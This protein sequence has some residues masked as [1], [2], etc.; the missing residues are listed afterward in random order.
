MKCHIKFISSVLISL[1]CFLVSLN[2]LAYEISADGYGKS[3]LIARKNATT[4]LSESLLT[5][6]RSELN[7]TQRLSGLHKVSKTVRAI[8]ELPLL[9]VEFSSIEYPTEYYS[10]AQLS[11]K[12]SL[13]LYSSQ[14][15]KIY[16]EVSHLYNR[17]KNDQIKGSAKYAV[18]SDLYLLT[19]KYPQYKT[20]ATLLGGSGYAELPVSQE[21]IGAKLILI[22]SSV[23][24][25]GLAVK[26]LIRKLP[27]NSYYVQAFMPRGSKQATQFSRLLKDKISSM[28]STIDTLSE[29][30]YYLKGRYEE[31]NNDIL[32]TMRATDDLGST[33]MSQS[34]RLNKSAVTGIAYKSNT[35]DFNKLL[36]E[37]YVVSNNFRAELNSNQ[38]NEGLLF[39]PGQTIE[40]FV[41]I[42]GPGYYYVVSHNTSN[43][44]SY[45]LELNEAEGKRAFV[46]YV[47]A[48]DVNRWV[49][50]GSFEVTEPYGTENLQLIASNK[51]LI[52]NLPKVKFD[53]KS[54]LYVVESGTAEKAII[55]TRGLKPKKKGKVKSAE[56]TLTF[57]TMPN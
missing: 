39:T 42:N 10:L 20:V 56:A 37:G 16:K 23:T 44:L 12:K 31:L 4:A 8:S 28:V 22:E 11:S 41:K 27:K 40:L 18:L 30:S 38:G 55:T 50:L 13:Q 32:I 24:T 21:E 9:G 34:V 53:A 19:E 52:N 6:V 15:N 49:S 5:E 25:I 51:D 29:A 33:L 36:H 54:E 43:D 1:S 35:V 47:N 2:S 57:T 45:V 48:D 3:A 46:S 17:L 7:S 26:A 14:V